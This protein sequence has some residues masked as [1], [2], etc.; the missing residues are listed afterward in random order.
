MGDKVGIFNPPE[1]NEK[2][3]KIPVFKNFIKSINSVDRFIYKKLGLQ[4]Q[5][6]LLSIYYPNLGSIIP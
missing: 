3:R 5:P 1:T 4:L 2:C 6:Q